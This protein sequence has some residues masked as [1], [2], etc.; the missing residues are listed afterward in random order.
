MADEKKERFSILGNKIKEH[1]AAAHSTD[2]TSTPGRAGSAKPTVFSSAN[3]PQSSVKPTSTTGSV[4]PTAATSSTVKPTA[5]TSATAKPSST[6]TA[7]SVRPTNAAAKPTQFT[8]VPANAYYA[9]AVAWA[10]KKG[11]TTGTTE[12]TFSPSNACHKG[13]AAAFIWRSKGSPAPK[14]NKN[15][16]TDVS[17]GPFYQAIL[18]AVENGIMEGETATTFAHTT[19]CTRGQ[20]LTYL[21]RAE[22][23]ANATEADAMK[24]AS[25]KKLLAGFSGNASAPCTRS[26]IVTFLYR[27]KNN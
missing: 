18:W 3:K 24:W 13:H 21:L 5:A 14:N 9:D 25:M 27:I 15:P 12:T 2:E 4:K 7:A 16:F 6:P 19:P 11:I 10:V 17:D 8:D 23:K 20:V 26:D 1:A 22:G